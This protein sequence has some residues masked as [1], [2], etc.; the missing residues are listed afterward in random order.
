NWGRIT[1]LIDGADAGQR[2]SLAQYQSSV[3]RA[4][5][6]VENSLATYLQE[7]QRNAALHNA[8]TADS[9][10]VKLARLRYEAG[11]TDLLEVLTVERNLLI[12]ESSVA[13]S[14]HALRQRLIT[15]QVAT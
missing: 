12:S 7:Q 13:L 10:A 3:L 9:N 8:F 2:A 15:L 1:S 4:L 11:S 5:E 6:E 14:D